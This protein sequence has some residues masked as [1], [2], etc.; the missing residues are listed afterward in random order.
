MSLCSCTG[1]KSLSFA[2]PTKND[3]SAPLI[4]KPQKNLAKPSSKLKTIESNGQDKTVASENTQ[5][6][7]TKEPE[8][9]PIKTKE[10]E[11]QPIKTKEPKNNSG[12][13]PK[14]P[15]REAIIP[16]K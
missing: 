6:P 1:I 3:A 14:L 4:V 16:P 7:K 15:E 8:I 9:Q 13:K 5:Q 12:L 2:K 10:P 11:I